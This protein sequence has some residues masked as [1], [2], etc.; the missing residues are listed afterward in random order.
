MKKTLL[1]ITLF[2]TGVCLGQTYQLAEEFYE[3]GLPKAIKTYKVS[4]AKLELVKGITWYANGR[5]K[6]EVT[7]KDGKR[8]GKWTSW[9]KNGQKSFEKTFKDGKEDGEWTE[10]YENG[11]KQVEATFK[12]GEI[13]GV[14]TLWDENGQKRYEGSV[15]DGNVYIDVF[16][17]VFVIDGIFNCFDGSKSIQ[18]SWVND[19][20]CDCS[21]CSDEPLMK[22]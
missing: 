21:D 17:S 9:Y 1:I 2:I 12:D 4:K 6:G 10:W 11:Q 14:G 8:D 13:V 3:N 16:K 18:A 19:R 22:R 15:K 5:K 20:E 7:Y